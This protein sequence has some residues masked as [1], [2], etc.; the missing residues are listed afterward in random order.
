MNQLVITNHADGGSSPPISRRR[1]LAFGITLAI[2]VL[3][4]GVGGLEAA[5]RI[6]DRY[7]LTSVQLVSL[8]APVVKL[9]ETAVAPYVDRLPIAPGVDRAWF[10][11]NP[12]QE[13]RPFDLDLERR[14]RS[15]RG[16]ELPAVYEWNEE[17]VRSAICDEPSGY[18]TIFKPLG[19]VF[20]FVPR[21]GRRFPQFRFL[22]S[23][24]LP[25]GLKTNNFGWRGPDIAL[26][27]PARTI[28]IAFVGGSVTIGLHRTPFS[29]P[30]HVRKWLEV[31]GA[32]RHPETKFEV[33]NAAR[34]G[35]AS[36]GIAAIARDEVAPI[37]P[38]LV[39][40]YEGGNSFWPLDFIEWPKGANAIPSTRPKNTP[41]KQAPWVLEGRSALVVR[42]KGLVQRSYLRSREPEKP[43]LPVKW[44][45]SLT[46]HDP[47]LDHAQLPAPVRTT[48][49]DLD[50]IRLALQP[51]A[52]RLG[53]SSFVWCVYDGMRLDPKTN[54]GVYEFLN[55]TFWPFSYFHLRRMVD[56]Q[57]R[58]LAKYAKERDADFIDA[59]RDFPVDPRLFFDAVH[60]LPP[61]SKLLG[62]TTFQQLVPLIDRRIAAGEWPRPARLHLTTHPAFDQPMRHLV[63][64]SAIRA[65]CVPRA[66]PLPP[67]HDE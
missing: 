17:Y 46:E 59:A 55:T 10:A 14:Y 58:V 42:V 62:W 47:Q 44:P 40:Y 26:E 38:D 9:D 31:W 22:R 53:A 63:Q 39:V 27:K 29:Y 20:T 50:T 32:S 28:R 43:V 7:A 45:A 1:P 64:A 16:Q 3:A 35:V 36:T 49:Q 15:H 65:S 24:H 41:P 66:T 48:M 34:E 11:L 33:V 67:A 54:V 25:S 21:D 4:L 52:A 37:D 23:A 12:A 2:A 13:T 30:D 56:F 5:F 61:G 6:I 19:E 60:M 8:P 57:N 51:T 18:E